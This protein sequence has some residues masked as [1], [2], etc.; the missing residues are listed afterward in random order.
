[1]R[2]P[3]IGSLRINREDRSTS[4]TSLRQSGKQPETS[5]G[6]PWKDILKEPR[7]ISK[8]KEEKHSQ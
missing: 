6:N 7:R 2:T 4:R 5:G 1:L 8:E 3:F